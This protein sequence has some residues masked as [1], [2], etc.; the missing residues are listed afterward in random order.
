LDNYAEYIALSRYARWVEEKGR[1]ETWPETV[2]RYIKFFEDRGSLDAT[3]A[4]NLADSI[5]DL[6]VMPSMRC[7]MTAGD[8]LN[9]DNVAGFNCSYLAIDHV[10]CF[11]E[12]MYILMCGTG[13]GFS[14]ERQ[15][16]AKLPE[17]PEELHE[18]DTTIAVADSKIGWASSF[19]QL[20]SLLY[21]GQIPKW[22]VSRV[23]AAGAPLK[24]FGGRASGPQPLEDLFS[25]AVNL[26][27]AA[28]GRKFN[29]IE[30]HDLVCKIADIVV[31]GGVRRSA[32]ISLSNLTD[33]R[34]R[35]AKSGQWWEDNGQR[36]LANNSACYTEKPDL[37]SF[38]KEWE[39]LYES[40]SGER[41]VFS[42]VASQRQAAK[43]VRRDSGWDFGTNPC[44]EIILRPN[45]FCNLSEV[46]VRAGDTMG[47]LERKVRQA[48]ILG[49]LQSTLTDFRYLRS[50]WK[51]NT[52]E[53]A[54]LGVSLTGIM[55]NAVLSNS[56]DDDLAALL[57]R[58]KEIVVE[59]NKEWAE[60]LGVNPSTATTCVNV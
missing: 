1:R 22:D 43:N 56:T 40:K 5:I 58:L 53:E 45:Q 47:D 42:R 26:F 23:R 50:V 57:E 6:E 10:R 20:I 7:L 49:T 36:A 8:A 52:E 34:M 29:S 35:R 25:F 3:L 37:I 51:R 19:K 33:D 14:V 41:G 13:V 15:Y 17:I 39:S 38:M 60:K 16:I 18:C 48:A 24:T 9:R 54:L 32:L 30:C 27:K 2:H 55:D 12:L 21:A 28:V 59:T 4:E 44:S 31:V 11:D 46:V